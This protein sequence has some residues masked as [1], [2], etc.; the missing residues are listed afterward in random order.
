MFAP[1]A[2]DVV[3]DSKLDFSIHIEHKIKRC[4]K[5]IAL[6]RRLSV[7]FPRKS[8]YINLLSD[9]KSTKAIFCMTN[10]TIKTLK[11]KLKR[12][13]IKLVFQYLVPCKGHLEKVSKRMSLKERHWYSKLSFLR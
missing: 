3:L 11:V 8:L 10:Q 12:F 2:L 13:I 5:I 7:C 9:L 6:L 1:K 4:N